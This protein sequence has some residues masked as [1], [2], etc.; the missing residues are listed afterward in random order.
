MYFA[1]A[2]ASLD[3]YRITAD[4]FLVA[5]VR[6][7]RT[8][9]QTYG[10][11]E[12]DR[13]DLAVVGVYRPAAEVFSAA[14]MRSFAHRPVTLGHPADG[15]SASSWRQHSIGS[16]GENITR[17][18]DFVRGTVIVQDA[19]AIEMI[20]NGTR[21]LSAGYNCDVHWEAGMAPDGQ[22]YQAVQRSIRGN[23]VAI[24]D[25][26]RAGAACRIGIAA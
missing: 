8:G 26:A 14:A 18:G 24:V 4:G 6:F 12:L 20:K 17:D 2:A 1:D 25:R 22:A 23:H 13:R 15:V 3:G 10:G 9:I 11:F 21:E 16:M 5:N 19:A 7:A